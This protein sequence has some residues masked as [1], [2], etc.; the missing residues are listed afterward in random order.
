MF[1]SLLKAGQA[2]RA[3]PS[4]HRSNGNNEIRLAT[5]STRDA[6][7]SESDNWRD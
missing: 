1:G 6:A 2:I 5:V 7:G 3:S 4:R